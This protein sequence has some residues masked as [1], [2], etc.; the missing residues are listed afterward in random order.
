MSDEKVQQVLALGRMGWS[1]REIERHTGVRRETASGYLTRAGVAIRPPR[2]RRDPRRKPASGGEASPDSSPPGTAKPASGG[3][4]SPDLRAA[5]AGQVSSAGGPSIGPEALGGQY[6]PRV[7]ACEPYRELIE[8]Q[9]RAG[10]HAKAIWQDLVTDHG[11]VAGYASVKRFARKLRGTTVP[12]ERVVISTPP[13]REAQVDYG[14][15]PMCRHPDTGKY[16]RTRLFV[17]TLGYSRK[18]VRLLVWRS[19]SRVWAELHERAFRRLGGAPAT[20]VFDNLKEGVLSPDVHDAT[21][22]PLFRDVLAHYGV[23]A[24]PCRVRDPDRKGKVE[25]SVGYAKGTL[26]GLRF[27]SIEDAQ[28]Y[29]DRWEARWADTRIHGTTKRQVAAMFDEERPHLRPLP[30]HPFRYYQ[31]GQRVVHLD[32]CVE[33]N[34]AYYHAPPGWIGRTVHVQWD[35]THVRLLDPRT[36]ELLREYVAARAGGRR[37]LDAD[38]PRRTPSSTAHLLGQLSHAGQ[39]VGAFGEKLTA[40][41]GP[42]DVIRKL[43]G[44]RAL[45][46]KHGAASVDE[47]AGVLL[48]MRVYDYRSLRRYLERRKPAPLSLKQVD[49]LIRELS[50]YRD[51]IDRLNEGVSE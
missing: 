42:E 32:G 12:E 50:M 31:H 36:G 17:L 7:S 11:F 23:V 34:R 26:R 22:N 48:E 25:S 39:H 6:S 37:V 19:S 41:H 44:V 14:D 15:G 46:K 10:R 51:Y 21:L 38:R 2:G 4:V 27:E 49:P 33:V 18:C 1:L 35:A 3:E 9:L 29:L 16:R 5:G 8:R 30:L 43:Q 47:A 45:V 24:L 20:L 28:R 13:G 40:A